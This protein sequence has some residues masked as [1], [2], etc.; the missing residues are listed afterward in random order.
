MGMLGNLWT[1]RHRHHFGTLQWLKGWAKRICISPALWRQWRIHSSLRSRGCHLGQD[2]F[3]ADA[4]GITGQHSLLR[5]GD[6]T[7]VGR[8]KI[9][10]HDQVT[11][12]AGVC[13]ND[14]TQLLSASHDV[15]S[16]SWNTVTAPIS[17]EDHAW[18][19]V[20]CLILPGV[21][22]GKGAVVGAGAVVTKDVEPYSIVVGNPAKPIPKKRQ[23]KL[24]YSPVEYVAL[25]RAWKSV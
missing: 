25:F 13:I 12:G 20:R 7:F 1:E 6:G 2:S 16:P 10:L 14:E 4:T 22:I 23:Q 5:V 19:A 18:I 9:A 8:V 11:I 15:M 21:T 24:E 3:I 17:I